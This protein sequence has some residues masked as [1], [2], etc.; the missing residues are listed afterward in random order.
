MKPATRTNSAVT[1]Q[2]RVISVC[3]GV[4]CGR[5]GRI[6]DQVSDHTPSPMPKL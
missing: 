6:L 3:D 4:G 2:A 5:F 1:R